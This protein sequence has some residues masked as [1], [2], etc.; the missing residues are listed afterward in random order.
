MKIVEFTT[1]K[2]GNK[3]DI[4]KVKIHVDFDYKNMLANDIALLKSVSFQDMKNLCLSKGLV[5]TDQD[6]QDAM[7]GT[8]YGRKGLV[9]GMEQSLEGNNPDTTSTKYSDHPSV[10]YVKVLNSTQENY[11]T[12]VIISEEIVAKDPNPQ[13]YKAVN[14]GIIVQLKNTIKK[15]F[16]L[17]TDKLKT[18]KLNSLDGLET[19]E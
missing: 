11:I 8:V 17:E 15:N 1:Q 16:N 10:L 2:Q 7:Y 18:Y 6:L 13:P 19:K 12:G 5:F 3:K 14:S 4:V 9:V